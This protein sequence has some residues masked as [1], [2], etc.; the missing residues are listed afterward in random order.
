[1]EDEQAK[2]ADIGGVTTV[3]D[4]DR[5]L[6]SVPYARFLGLS[7][8]L[9]SAGRLVMLMKGSDRLVGNPVLRATHGGAIGA[10]LESAA[11]FGAMWESRLT[12]VPKTISVTFDY[13]R[14]ARV[15]DTYALARVTKLGRRVASVQVQAWQ[16]DETKAVAAARAHLLLHPE[17]EATEAPSRG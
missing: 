13:L 15:L 5:L 7:A 3:A 8:E 4:V 1:M 17:G 14:S 16:D 10:L 12:R 11:L 6:Q 9:D 2:G